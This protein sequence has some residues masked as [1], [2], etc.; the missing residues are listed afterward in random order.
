VKALCGPASTPEIS[1]VSVAPE[2]SSETAPSGRVS[3][4]GRD[5]P[6]SWRHFLRATADTFERLR[7]L[8]RRVP[9]LLVVDAPH[10]DIVHPRTRLEARTVFR[11]ANT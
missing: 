8:A 2:L 9:R 1:A 4:I 10:V 3:M 7:A 6:A 5:A 11:K